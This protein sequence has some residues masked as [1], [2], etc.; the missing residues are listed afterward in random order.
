MR[1]VDRNLEQRLKALDVSTDVDALLALGCDLADQYHDTD[2][3]TCFRRAAD[4]GSS[5]GAYNL[6]NSLAVQ[7]RWLEAVTAFETAA[8]GGVTDAWFNLG[9]VLHE[10]GDLA[11]EIRAYER[12]EA[13]GDTNGTLGLAFCLREQ[14]DQAGAM[15][16]AQRAAAAGNAK[17]A[18]V[19]ACWKW[20]QTQDHSLEDALRTGAEQYQSARAALAHLLVDTDRIDEARNVLERGAKL[21]EVDS[22]L[23]LGNLYSDY[24]DDDE[25]AEA[26]YRAGIVAGDLHCHHNLGLLLEERGELEHAAEQ[27][28][29]GAAGGD[30]LAA[31][32]LTNL[33]EP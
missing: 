9:Q 4:L 17:A 32:A 27:Y 24:L 10:L 14:G 21:G 31:R 18:G 3:E 23:P 6:G 15:E 26:A 28:R 22:W 7:E 20:D 25:A 19:V 11:G 13:A 2:A 12:A 29:L 30:G 5:L 8:A 1:T 33:L 16:T